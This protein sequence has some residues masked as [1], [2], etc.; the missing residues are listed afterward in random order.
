MVF[1]SGCATAPSVRKITLQEICDQR[2]ISCQWDS[3]S[4]DVFLHKKDKKASAQVGSDTVMVGSQ[5]VRLSRAIE[6]HRQAIVVP[7]DF[8]VKV[9]ERLLETPEVMR[10]RPLKIVVDAGHGGND[11]GAIGRFGIKE[12]DIVLDLAKRLE[13]NLRDRGIDVVMTR[14]RDESVSLER[15]T[16]IATRAQADFFIS[17]HAN[18]NPSKGIDGIQVYSCKEMGFKEKND[19]QL[20]KNYDLLFGGLLMQRDKYVKQIVADMLAAYK[21]SESSAVASSLASQLVRDLH[22][23]NRGIKRSGFFVVRNTLLPAVLVETGFLTNAREAKRLNTPSYRQDIA[24]SL[25]ENLLR[26]FSR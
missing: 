20:R 25:S 17:I 18:S 24:D 9:I 13:R 16:E 1:A 23:A 19:E 2:G 12:K 3:V 6:R 5:P 15:R 10:E 11:P 4:P 7:E 8:E 14:T 21:R 22:V 26:H